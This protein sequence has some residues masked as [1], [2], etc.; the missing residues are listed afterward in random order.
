MNISW[1][2]LFI[3]SLI[4]FSDIY[5]RA[6]KLN[7]S[8]DHLW[9]L[10]P[11][12]Q[13]PLFNLIP[14]LM[15]K[16]KKIRRGGMNPR[17]KDGKPYDIFILM[18]ILMKYFV[19]VAVTSESGSPLLIDIV[20]TYIAILLP[21][22]IRHYSPGNNT[23]LQSKWKNPLFRVMGQSGMIYLGIFS[24]IYLIPKMKMVNGLF[25]EIATMFML[26]IPAYIITNM[27]NE[28]NIKEFCFKDKDANKILTYGV[29]AFIIV[30]KMVHSLKFSD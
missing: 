25:G 14:L 8:I 28:N 10:I 7:G 26:Y 20:G 2:N 11:L 17:I 16:F 12:F 22:L 19:N 23:C 4:P 30:A 9:T 29:V 13:L 21:F 18:F 27:L 15:M 6:T 24:I 1:L 3:Y 5:L